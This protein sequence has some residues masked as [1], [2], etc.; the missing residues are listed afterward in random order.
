M[1]KRPAAREGSSATVV[2]IACDVGLP[3]KVEKIALVTV[4]AFSPR[5]LAFLVESQLA[6]G[7]SVVAKMTRNPEPRCRCLYPAAH[8]RQLRAPSTCWGGFPYL[9]TSR[10]EGF[11]AGTWA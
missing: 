1:D 5:G 9:L 3:F 4:L 2:I 6:K 10:A 7:T 8:C 11:G